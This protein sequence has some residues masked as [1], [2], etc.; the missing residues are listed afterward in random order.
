MGRHFGR[1]F[2]AFSTVRIVITNGLRRA[3]LGA[4]ALSAFLQQTTHTERREYDVFT[5]LLGMDEGRL[6]SHIEKADSTEEIH[7]LADMIQKGA[8]ASCADDTK[9]M[10]GAII[11]WITPPDGHLTPP[12]NRRL[13]STR[14]YRHEATGALLCPANLDWN[15]PQTKEKLAN[16]LLIVAGHSWPLFLYENSKYD[17]EKP[18]DGLLKGKIL[19]TA[20][21]HVFIAPSSVDSADDVAAKGGNAQ[22][23]GMKHVTKASLVYIA[24]QVRFALSSASTW[25]R[26]DKDTDSETFYNSL[27]TTLEDPRFAVEVNDIIRWWNHKIFPHSKPDAVVVPV[28][29][30]P[31]DRILQQQIEQ[32]FQAAGAAASAAGPGSS[33]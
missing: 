6:E 8:G 26:T 22:I 16:G 27:I 11:D 25:S 17:P 2:C 29:G 12:L 32:E 33:S 14:G 21:K 15:D 4:E 18:W 7:N 19:I 20:F 28:T 1:I 10:K 3:A 5:S 13:K 30:S 24:T 31:L 9:S 23:N